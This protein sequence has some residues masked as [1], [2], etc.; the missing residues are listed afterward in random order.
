MTRKE[1]KAAHRAA[2]IARQKQDAPAVSLVC[3]AKDRP[4]PLEGLEADLRRLM[5]TGAAEAAEFMTLPSLGRLFSPRRVLAVLAVAAA[6]VAGLTVSL[7]HGA[8][9]PADAGV[10]E[11]SAPDGLA[12]LPP[13]APS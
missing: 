13:T 1:W 2:R 4:D 7:S 11:V 10:T 12:A 8:G 6:L 9:T 5:R 3:P